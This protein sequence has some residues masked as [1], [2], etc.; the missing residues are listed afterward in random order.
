MEWDEITAS[1]RAG[2]LDPPPP[3]TPNARS[4]ERVAFINDVHAE[5][6]DTLLWGQVLSWL[7]E[8]RPERLVIN[9]DFLDNPSI[10]RFVHNPLTVTSLKR[11]TDT[12]KQMLR[13]LRQAVGPGC[14]I[15]FTE[16]NHEKRIRLWIGTQGLALAGMEGTTLAEM[17]EF[18][19]LNINHHGDE[20]FRLRP[21]FH[22]YH[23]VLVPKSNGF[24][25]A[26]RAEL[27]KW[28]MSGISGH[29]HY[30]DTATKDLG[31]GP[32][33]WWSNGCLC[34]LQVDYVTGPT[35]WHHSVAVGEFD[36][37]SDHFTMEQVVIRDRQLVY[38]GR[39]YI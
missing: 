4:F 2:K 37:N 18:E 21:N 33:Q 28:N 29:T 17:L 22:V 20:G 13:Q 39:T 12:G 35:G 30:A 9:G 11:E 27:S 36:R 10:S 19:D 31:R 34:T 38:R 32:M 5:H 15:D 16:G 24:S 1:E 14:I 8:I 25:T 26:A 3:P 7:R 23:G 6:V